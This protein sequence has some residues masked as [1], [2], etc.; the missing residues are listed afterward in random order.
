VLAFY[1]LVISRSCKAADHIAT[2]TLM[3]L[4][5]EHKIAVSVLTVSPVLLVVVQQ[6]ARQVG[7]RIALHVWSACSIIGSTS[8]Q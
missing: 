8:D 3:K 5:F 4:L 2:I 7:V 1:K 6:A